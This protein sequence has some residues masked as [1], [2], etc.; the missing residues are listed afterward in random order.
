M[1]P[2]AEA[3]LAVTAATT[4]LAVVEVG[5]VEPGEELS[6]LPPM[7]E[8]V[9]LPGIYAIRHPCAAVFIWMISRPPSRSGGI[10]SQA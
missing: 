10:T 8:G 3:V 4:L 1:D 6:L 2:V 9:A 7:R 5:K